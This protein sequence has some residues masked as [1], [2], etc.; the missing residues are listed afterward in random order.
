[1]KPG[2]SGEQ[3]PNQ[4]AAPPRKF[5][6]EVCVDS[7]SHA[8]AAMDAGA[9]RIEM[10]CALEL[11]GLTPPAA[12]CQWLV[13]HGHVP[14]VAMLRPHDRGFIYTP[15]EELALLRDCQGLLDAGVAGIVF[16]SLDPAG[17][18][19]LPMLQKVMALCSGRE[20][21]FH[22]AFDRLA[23]QLAGLE[24]LVECGVKRILTSGGASSALAGAAQLRRLVE[25]SASRIE[26]LPAAGIHSG[27]ARKILLKSGCQQ[28]HGSFR[29][30]RSRSEP[31][32]PREIAAGT[33]EKET[34][35]QGPNLADIASTVRIAAEVCASQ[36]QA[37]S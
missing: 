27:N 21:I 8:M 31:P 35:S 9:T 5:E 14:I 2:A 3:Q 7:V 1:M 16:G 32:G 18:I 24:I 37:L 33:T 25:A 10:N 15:S 23:D 17:K 11:D 30:K 13:E 28:L 34:H 4:Q 6:I 20:V 26:I 12:S 22:R 29:G 19:A 36:N